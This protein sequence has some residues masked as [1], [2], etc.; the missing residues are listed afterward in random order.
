MDRKEIINYHVSKVNHKNYEMNKKRKILQINVL[1]TEFL[2]LCNIF[3]SVK[4]IVKRVWL[5]II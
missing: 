5:K 2:F 4:R 3:R 1:W